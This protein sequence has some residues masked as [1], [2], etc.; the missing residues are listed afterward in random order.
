MQCYIYKS[1]IKKQT[2]LYLLEKD[3]FSV[4]PETLFKLFGLPEFCF[5]FALT[6]EKK[7]FQENTRIVINNLQQQ[8]YHLQVSEKDIELTLQPWLQNT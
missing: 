3:E 1:P 6:E 7:L 2:Y 5:D 4:L 8:G